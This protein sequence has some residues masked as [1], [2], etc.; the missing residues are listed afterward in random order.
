[1]LAGRDILQVGD[2]NL[3]LAKVINAEETACHWRG[4][5]STPSPL[6][7]CCAR[8]AGFVVSHGCR[9]LQFWDIEAL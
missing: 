5:A 3:R 9:C 6:L 1:M 8:L 7:A 4:A 2:A